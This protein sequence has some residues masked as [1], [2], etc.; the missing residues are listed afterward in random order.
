[1]IVSG[2]RALSNEARGHVA[3]QSGGASPSA[4]ISEDPEG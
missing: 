1:M 3:S 4:W 2:Q